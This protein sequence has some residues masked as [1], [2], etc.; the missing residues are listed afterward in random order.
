MP[1]VATLI[2]NPRDSLLSPALGDKAFGAV[3]ASG[4]YWLADGMA[5]DIV[6]MDGADGAAAEAALRSALDGAPVDVVVQD[7]DTRRKKILIADMDSTMIGQ[8]CID[9]LADEAG[10]KAHVAAITARA[11][12]GEIEFEPALRERVGL[13]KGLPVSVIGSVIASR[14]TPTPSPAPGSS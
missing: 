3:E 12:N 9:E 5:C 7:Q 14:I 6:L 2:A 10:L 11:M 8:E 1:L 13:L 4:L